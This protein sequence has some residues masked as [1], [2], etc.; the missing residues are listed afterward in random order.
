MNEGCQFCQGGPCMNIC[1]KFDV[2]DNTERHD[3]KE[4][5]F[6]NT[7]PFLVNNGSFHTEEV[8]HVLN[9]CILAQLKCDLTKWN[10]RNE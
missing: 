3:I 1:A 5:P 9:G 2:C 10:Q 4:C 8:E 6:C 7:V